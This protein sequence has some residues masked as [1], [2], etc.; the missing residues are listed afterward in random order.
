MKKRKFA[1]GGDVEGDDAGLSTYEK[2][3][4]F[5]R[6][7]GISDDTPALDEKIGAS[8]MGRGETVRTEIPSRGGSLP[9]TRENTVT[10][11]PVPE[12]G[13]IA[14][15][16]LPRSPAPASP[17]PTVTRTEIPAGDGGVPMTRETTI[18]PDPAEE[19]RRAR[20]AVMANAAASRAG[21]QATAAANP[22]TGG[23]SPQASDLVS[24]IGSAASLAGMGGAAAAALRGAAR[25]GANAMARQQYRRGQTGPATRSEGQSRGVSRMEGEGNIPITPRRSRPANRPP[26][27]L[28]EERMA[29]EGGRNF[30]RGG[31]VSSASSRADGIAKRGRTRGRVL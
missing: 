15:S 5:L 7:Q 21:R 19:A 2:A 20:G 3:K 25:G 1:D 4:R 10:P 9:M 26:R 14:R 13:R 23:M 12:M 11:E 27:D 28:D 22:D 29:G 6:R 31:S 16:P 24:K 30:K 8:R 17:A 18:E